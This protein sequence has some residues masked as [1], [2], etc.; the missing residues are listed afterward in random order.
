MI[1]QQW[2]NYDDFM[3]KYGSENN[4]EAWTSWLSI[5]AFFNGV[6]VLVKRGKIDIDLVE[7]LLANAVLIAWFRMS[8][9]ILGWRERD[10]QFKGLGR[11]GNYPFLHGFEYLYNEIKKRES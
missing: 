2:K 4:L 11:S 10:P 6:G 3:N 5:G 7:E 1:Q 9:I 8:P